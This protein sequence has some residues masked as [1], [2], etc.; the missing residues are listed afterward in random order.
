MKSPY[1]ILTLLLVLN[2]LAPLAPVK[3]CGMPC[4]RRAAAMERESGCCGHGPKFTRTAH[5]PCCSVSSPAE[6]DPATLNSQPTDSPAAYAHSSTA[7]TL[8]ASEGRRSSTTFPPAN[9]AGPTPVYLLNS[10]FRC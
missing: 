7:V 6:S 9:R 8:I 4:C 1:I 3:T 5:K 10:T 2:M